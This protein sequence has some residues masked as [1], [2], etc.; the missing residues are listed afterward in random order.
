MNKILYSILLILAYTQLYAC[1][2]EKDENTVLEEIN[3][4]KE[5]TIKLKISIGNKVLSATLID[6]VT[7]QAFVKMLPLTIH[8]TELYNNEKYGHLSSKLPGK[9][10]K[11]GTIQAGDLMLWDADYKCLVLF[12]K[13]FK[14]PYSY[15]KLG[16]VDKPDELENFLG[17]G[18]VK[19]KFELEK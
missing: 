17:S 14:S 9:A 1:N 19:I 5:N 4:S 3:I 8:M 6:N 10:I 13:T 12:Y 2:L 11:P 18:N 15:V 16:T 7:T